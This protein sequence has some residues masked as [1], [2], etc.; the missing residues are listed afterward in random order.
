MLSSVISAAVL[1][2]G[3]GCGTSSEAPVTKAELDAFNDARHGAVDTAFSIEQADLYDEVQVPGIGCPWG[4]GTS[5]DLP[6]PS[7]RME[8]NAEALRQACANAAE[9]IADRRDEAG[10]VPDPLLAD[11]SDR[12]LGDLLRI[13]EQCSV[14]GSLGDFRADLEEWQRDVRPAGRQLGDRLDELEDELSRE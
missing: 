6:S 14:S 9:I 5:C 12:A 13:V 1:L 3:A 8:F 2:A 7:T 10:D 4:G 11:I